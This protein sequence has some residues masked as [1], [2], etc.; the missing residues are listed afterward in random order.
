MSPVPCLKPAQSGSVWRGRVCH[1]ELLAL[2]WGRVSLRGIW[3]GQCS[4]TSPPTKGPITAGTGAPVCGSE[5][6]ISGKEPGTAAETQGP[7]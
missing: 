2:N 5:G 7:V 6:V 1:L 3:K 4:Q